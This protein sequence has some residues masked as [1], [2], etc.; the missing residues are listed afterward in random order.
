MKWYD[1][2]FRLLGNRRLMT[3]E[4]FWARVRAES[5]A[6]NIRVVDRRQHELLVEVA[7][8]ASL[9]VG[10][11]Q[12]QR[13]TI[14]ADVMRRLQTAVMTYKIVEQDANTPH[15]TIK[16]GEVEMLEMPGR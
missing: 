13:A 2:L 5:E 14:D 11:W 10:V 15:S 3:E 4:E 7:A 9:A 1:R 6:K 12:R 8:L 16:I